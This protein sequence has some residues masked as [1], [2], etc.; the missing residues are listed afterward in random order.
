[1]S[2][3]KDGKVFILIRKIVNGFYRVDEQNFYR[4]KPL[5]Y[6]Q[7]IGVIGYVTRGRAEVD[8]RAGVRADVSE[9]VNMRHYVVP[10]LLFILVFFIVIDIVNMLFHLG[11]LLV[12]NVKPELFFALRKGNPKFAPRRISVVRGENFL[13]FFVRISFA[14]RTYVFIFHL[15]LFCLRGI[16]Q[17]GTQRKQEYYITFLSILQSL[18]CMFS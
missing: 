10:K 9:S 12:R 16:S 2:V 17:T 3:S 6:E 15:V 5:F 13:H 1:M 14:K 11:D 18:E 7:N 4:F 8:Y